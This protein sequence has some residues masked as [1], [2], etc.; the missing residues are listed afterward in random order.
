METLFL[1]KDITSKEAI[2]AKTDACFVRMETGQILLRLL[3]I[4]VELEILRIQ[5]HK[6]IPALNSACMLKSG[7]DR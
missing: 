4:L 6:T 2:A 5:T 3:K 7:P 1:L